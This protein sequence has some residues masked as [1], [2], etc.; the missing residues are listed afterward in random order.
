MSPEIDSS[1]YG[2][3]IEFQFGGEKEEP[4]IKQK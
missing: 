1:I 4:F 2:D 3:L